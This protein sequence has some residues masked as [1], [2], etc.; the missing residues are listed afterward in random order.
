MSSTFRL[1]RKK[2][3]SGEI[4]SQTDPY[5]ALKQT[6]ASF[7]VGPNGQSAKKVIIIRKN[8]YVS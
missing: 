5:E 4:R 3:E 6:V 2:S 7:S 1:N 8:Y